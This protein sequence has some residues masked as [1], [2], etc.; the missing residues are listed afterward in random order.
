MVTETLPPLLIHLL[1]QGL[2]LDCLNIE[3]MKKIFLTCVF[4][5]VIASFCFGQ[6]NMIKKKVN[7]LY[8][9]DFHDKPPVSTVNVF[10]DPSERDTIYKLPQ[11][12][13]K[14]VCRLLKIDGILYVKLKLGTRLLTLN[15]V[16]VL[17]NIPVKFRKYRIKIND[18]EINSPE[19]LLISTNIISKVKLDKTSP[20]NYINIIE[21]G[22]YNDK[23]EIEKQMKNG[24]EY[25][26]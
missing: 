22:Y 19:S 18:M 10:V 9:V 1:L 6:K 26:N 24:D 17:Y 8:I 14:E 21:K 4:F 15:D 20:N 11:I 13:S 5:S 3:I 2:S 25:I 12:Q 16:F 7:F 23:R